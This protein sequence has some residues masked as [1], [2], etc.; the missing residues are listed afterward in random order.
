MPTN[1]IIEIQLA[2][3]R[4]KTIIDKQFKP[5]I[6]F[7][8]NSG[9]GILYECQSGYANLSIMVNGEIQWVKLHRF[10]LQQYGYSTD[11]YLVD[12]INRNKL[13]NRMENLRVV[14]SQQNAWNTSKFSTNTTGYYGVS[15][16]KQSGKYRPCISSPIENK[17][18]KLGYYSDKEDA[19]KVFDIVAKSFRGEHCHHNNL[20][21]NET[22]EDIVFRNYN[23][24]R[25]A[26]KLLERINNFILEARA[27]SIK[28]GY[29]AE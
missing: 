23:S 20:P 11:N 18:V 6:D 25:K 5:L 2:P 7:Y 4:N 10:L 22:L 16:D 12:H 21:I 28:Q 9:N 14:S 3:T 17:T 24:V 29:L 1:K 19:A 27:Y 26:K 15:Y 13:D 8:L